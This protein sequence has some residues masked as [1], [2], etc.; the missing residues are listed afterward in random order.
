MAGFHVDR[1]A[2][3][4]QCWILCG[5]IS[6]TGWIGT[7]EPF[8]ALAADGDW[9]L[10]RW[11]APVMSTGPRGRVPIVSLPSCSKINPDAVVG[12]IPKETWLFFIFAGSER[13]PKE[14]LAF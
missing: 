1:G 6:S 3:R 11:L 5:Q 9:L 7:Q 2:V 13:S 10:R 12:Q 8:F 14:M 4:Y